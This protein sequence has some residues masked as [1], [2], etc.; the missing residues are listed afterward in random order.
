VLTPISQLLGSEDWLFFP[1]K[2]SARRGDQDF[3]RS[4]RNLCRTPSSFP[5]EQSSLAPTIG[6]C[7]RAFLTSLH[8]SVSDSQSSVEPSVELLTEVLSRFTP[9]PHRLELLVSVMGR[10]G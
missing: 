6:K 2:I 3:S 8:A 7:S 9:L 1:K 5:R 4:T 10:F